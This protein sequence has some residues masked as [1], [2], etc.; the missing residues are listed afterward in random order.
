MVD[1]EN[2]IGL[3]H[4]NGKGNCPGG[5]NVRGGICPGGNVR[6]PHTNI[7]RHSRRQ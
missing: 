3:H 2:F 5:R 7:A 4:V 1:G 6:I